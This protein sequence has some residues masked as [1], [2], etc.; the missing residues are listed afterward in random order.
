MGT[1]YGHE[2]D[3]K[4]PSPLIPP[5]ATID[6]PARSQLWVLAHAKL[7]GLMVIQPEPRLFGKQEL[8]CTNRIA[9]EE[10]EKMFWL[11]IANYANETRQ[12]LKY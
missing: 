5:S 2:T 7:F 9:Y 12:I 3:I 6:I 10:P 11:F 4:T 8:I 1:P